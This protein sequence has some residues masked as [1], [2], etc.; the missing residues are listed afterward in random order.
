MICSLLWSFG[1]DAKIQTNIIA[2][3][4]RHPAFPPLFLGTVS[5]LFFFLFFILFIP[6]QLSLVVTD[7]K[8]LKKP[9]IIFPPHKL[10]LTVPIDSCLGH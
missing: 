7:K 4:R 1:N 9:F 2:C 8:G 5:A 6:Q 10:F 3:H